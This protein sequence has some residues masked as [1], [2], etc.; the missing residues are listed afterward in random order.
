MDLFS[1]SASNG[2][3]TA[4][5]GHRV[6]QHPSSHFSKFLPA[7]P[8]GIPDWEAAV[9]NNSLHK[10]LN[11]VA[12]VSGGVLG[13]LLTRPLRTWDARL[14]RYFAMSPDMRK[15]ATF[16]RQFSCE[17]CGD[18]GEEVDADE[19]GLFVP[20]AV[21]DLAPDGGFCSAVEISAGKQ[22]SVRQGVRFAVWALMDVLE[23]TLN[24]TAELP[25]TVSAED[26][27][28]LEQ[29]VQELHWSRSTSWQTMPEDLK[30]R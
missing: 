14:L 15:C 24:P 28:S 26:L 8:N 30:H 3:W 2:S 1:T 11:I 29:R 7:D 18:A 19:T 20:P 12:A 16:Q 27:P 9:S 13:D 4:S 21:Q 17:Q 5:S 23:H 10:Y 22:F 25:G 6:W